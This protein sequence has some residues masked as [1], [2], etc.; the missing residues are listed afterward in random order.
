[1]DHDACAAL[2]VALATEFEVPVIEQF[3]LYNGI[4]LYG[5]LFRAGHPLK[6]NGPSR[7]LGITIEDL[8]AWAIGVG[9]YP[10]QFKTWLGLWP[11]MFTAVAFRGFFV[12]R[13]VPDRVK[14]RP[15]AGRLLYE[16]LYGVPYDEVRQ[17]IDA[18]LSSATRTASDR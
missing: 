6:E 1:M 3:S 16:R 14:E 18:F 13:L 4:G 10:S 7:R 11:V 12:Q 15:H 2:A 8:T 9:H 17:K 5:P